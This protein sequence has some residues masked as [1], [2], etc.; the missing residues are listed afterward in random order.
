MTENAIHILEESIVRR[1]DRRDLHVSLN[2]L[3][4]ALNEFFRHIPESAR[5]KALFVGV[6]HGHDAM[7]ALLNGYV[8]SVVGVDTYGD[9]E[10]GE[11]GNDAVDYQELQDLIDK[12]GVRDRFVVHKETVQSY[13][14]ATQ[15]RFDLIVCADVLH[16]IFETTELL[17]RSSSF[18]P[19]AQLFNEFA[20]VSNPNA[21]VAIS[22][23]QRHGLR[24]FLKQI[25]IL[26]GHVY[27]THKQPWSEWRKA[28]EAS[29]WKL[30][31]LVNYIPYAFRNQQWFWS[32]FWGRYTLCD[33]YYLFLTKK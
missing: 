24:P 30:H 6:G 31:Q 21:C 12:C 13:L 33:R 4:Y 18:E 16:H 17:S 1:A 22:E 14:A 11:E 10:G 15:E 7:L 3:R 5:G 20:K 25:G 9:E 2:H 32:P 29:S 23:F 26:K 8:Q 19:A 27:Y 28:G